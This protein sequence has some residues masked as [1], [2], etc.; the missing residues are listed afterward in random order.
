MNKIDINKRIGVLLCTTLVAMAADA[1]KLTTQNEKVDCGQI[2]YLHPVT[3]EFQMKNDGNPLLV[4]K[5]L[6]MIHP[7]SKIGAIENALYNRIEIPII[8]LYPG[9]AQGTARTFLNI[10]TMDGNYRSKNF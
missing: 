6:E 4:I 5:D 7:Y 10:Y 8:I 1:Q 3:A 9:S 2:V